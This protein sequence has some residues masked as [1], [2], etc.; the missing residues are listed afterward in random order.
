[1]EELFSGKTLVTFGYLQPTGDIIA[2]LKQWK[3]TDIEALYQV[4][5]EQQGRGHIMSMTMSRS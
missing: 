2:K 1:M 5:A 4:I 3:D